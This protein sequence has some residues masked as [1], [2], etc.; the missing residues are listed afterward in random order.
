MASTNALSAFSF[1]NISNL[2]SIKLDA[3]NDLLWH[4][5]IT[6]FLLC[7]DLMSYVD[8]TISPPPKP[9][10]TTSKSSDKSSEQSS[11]ISYSEWQKKDQFLLSC[12]K[13]TLSPSAQAQVLG[14]ASS[15]QVWTTL[16]TIFNQQCQ[17]ELDLLRDE[18]Q[19]INKGSMSIEEYLA[20]I[21]SI[22]DNLAAINNPISDSELVTRTLNGLPHTMEYQPIVV[23]I[24]N[25]ENPISFNDLKARLLV[26][27]QRLK[28]LQALSP[29]PLLSTGSSHDTALVTRQ[30]YQNRGGQW[31]NNRGGRHGGQN[32]QRYDN[33]RYDNRD[34]RSFSRF[35]TPR[36]DTQFPTHRDNRDNRNFPRPQYG[37][38]GPLRCQICNQFDHTAVT[39]GY[40]YNKADQNLST[41]FAGLHLSSTASHDGFPSTSSTSIGANGESIWLADSGA[42]SHMTSNPS[43]L[44]QSTLYSGNDGAYIGD[45]R[46]GSTARGLLLNPYVVDPVFS[47][48]PSTSHD[49]SSIVN[50]PV[51]PFQEVEDV[52]DRVEQAD[53]IE[54]DHHSE[55]IPLLTDLDAPIIDDSIPSTTIAPLPQQAIEPLQS[56]LGSTH[57]MMTR[58]RDGT[59]KPKVPYS[60]DAATSK[61]LVSS[62]SFEPTSFKEACKDSKWISTMK[63][64]YTTLLQNGTWSLVLKTPNMNIVGCRWFYKIKERADGTIERYK[65][66]LVAKGYTQQEGIDFDYTFNPVVK[67][68]TIQIVLSLAISRGW[69]IRQLD[70]KNAFLHGQLNEEVFMAQPPGF[71]DSKQPNYVC[72]LHRSIYGLRQAP[73]AWFQRFSN[74]LYD[75]GFSSSHADP[76][77]I[78]GALQYLTFTRLDITY[79]VQQVCQFMHAP[80]DVHVQ[81]VKRIL[82]YL[83]GTSSCGIRFLPCH[84]S[85]LVCYVDAGW[86][87]CP[88][89]RHS[90]MG[91][92][93]F[94]GS[95]PISWS[96]KKQVS[97]AQSSTEAEYMALSIASRDVLWISYILR[98]IGFPTKHIETSYHF[99]RDLVCK[100]FL[101]VF[102]VRSQSQLVEFFTKGLSSPVFHPFKHKLLW[103]SPQ[104]FEGA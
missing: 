11:T 4:D 55:A 99:I 97:V 9:T 18:L 31:N 2:I 17:A 65:P 5:Q 69:P 64:E 29:Q 22:A 42:T 68:T 61:G 8:G 91:H 75:L 28:R 77:I 46:S 12:L 60:L 34:S 103:C 10:E 81:A 53:T 62:S 101:Q 26:H 41:S 1:A 66:R 98:E 52:N 24:E 21:K 54:N 49:C 50:L 36:Y 74:A 40:R 51:Q 43:L 6:P 48:P 93:I 67:A 13:A 30:S 96:T 70:V 57:P 87:G 83:K 27:E 47:L 16:E 84:S 33:Q 38:R 88:D 39:C 78:V 76:S 58:S 23:A 56:T 94:L 89:T 35:G 63:E 59:R 25:R 86:A 73:R 95:N 79:V 19:S 14:L 85:S 104:S 72:K 37:N 3:E 80:R 15:R 71:V 90:T 102:H 32:N 100:R 45:E 20:K 44:Q 82:R 92:C 7:S